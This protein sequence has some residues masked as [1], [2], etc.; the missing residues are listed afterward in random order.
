[1]PSLWAWGTGQAGQL[2]DGEGK[3]S[4]LP[5]GVSD[6]TFSAN[7]RQIAAG[8]SHCVALD[9]AGAVYAWGRTREGQAGR[10]DPTPQ[11]EPVVISSLLEHTV[12]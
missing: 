10:V 9:D 6:A 4:L 2:G 5:T 12:T 8:E 7:I 1:M 3:A 11:K